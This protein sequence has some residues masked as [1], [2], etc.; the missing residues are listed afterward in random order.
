MNPLLDIRWITR[1]GEPIKIRDMTEAHAK[2]S[3]AFIMDKIAA[4]HPVWCDPITGQFKY[5]PT[6]TNAP[7]VAR[8]L[9]RG[10]IISQMNDLLDKIK[11]P[12]NDML[13]EKI[14]DPRNSNNI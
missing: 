5:D 4:G 14:K 13:A 9:E 7:F 1:H 3:L 2:N 12:M 6:K 11:D 8:S 10:L